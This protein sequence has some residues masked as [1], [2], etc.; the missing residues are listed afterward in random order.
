MKNG[1]YEVSRR[2]RPARCWQAPGR[3]RPPGESSSNGRSLRQA[4]RASDHESPQ[5]VRAIAGRQR[6]Q[7]AQGSVVTRTRGAGSRRHAQ[8]ELSASHHHGAGRNNVGVAHRQLPA[9]RVL[10]IVGSQHACINV[11]SHALFQRTCPSG[12]PARP[13]VLPNLRQVHRGARL[14]AARGYRDTAPRREQNWHDPST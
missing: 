8:G 3:D 9:R 13:A 6:G 4:P 14:A 1:R 12:N 7:P 11:T 10:S 2:M 5:A